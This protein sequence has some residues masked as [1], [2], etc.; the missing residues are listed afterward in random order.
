MDRGRPRPPIRT[1]FEDS[2]QH[3]SDPGRDASRTKRGDM[4]SRSAARRAPRMTT[5]VF[6]RGGDDAR[7]FGTPSLA[8][9]AD[10][11]ALASVVRDEAARTEGGRWV[12]LGGLDAARVDPTSP[13][14][15][16][17][18]DAA[19]PSHPVCLFTADL[20]RAALNSAAIA[21][22]HAPTRVLDFPA[23]DVVRRVLPKWTLEVW[24]DRLAPFAEDLVRRG[25]TEIVDLD[26]EAAEGWRVLDDEGLLPLPLRVGTTCAARHLRRRVREGDRSGKGY[27]RVV[28]AGV[29][30][31]FDRAAWS[32]ERTVEELGLAR[33]AGI[34][35]YAAAVAEAARAAAAELLLASGP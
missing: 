2:A 33:D 13:A 24:K 10:A 9:C 28:L 21:F 18:L 12:V 31:D 15:A 20:R 3:R 19:S 6:V 35:V 11:A 4:R 14:F 7:L 16:A 32:R 30:V 17:A 5:P 22:A 26:D 27:G 1:E 8:P 25:A 34:R 29:V 23:T